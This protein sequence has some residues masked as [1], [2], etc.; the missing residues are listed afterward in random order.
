MNGKSA[1]FSHQKKGVPVGIIINFPTADW[2]L[3]VRTST[4]TF[5]SLHDSIHPKWKENIK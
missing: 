3:F 2:D 4:G 5:A 1:I